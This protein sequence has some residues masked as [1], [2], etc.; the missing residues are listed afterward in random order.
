MLVGSAAA[1][2]TGTGVEEGGEVET[3]IL[4]AEVGV[5][6]RLEHGNTWVYGHEVEGVMLYHGGYVHVGMHHAW[7]HAHVWPEVIVDVLWVYWHLH[8]GSWLKTI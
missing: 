1:V 7:M 3:G 4:A 2:R 5:G 6:V 8:T